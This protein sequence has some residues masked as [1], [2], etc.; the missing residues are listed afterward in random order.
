MNTYDP[1]GSLHQYR[2][3]LARRELAATITWAVITVVASMLILAAIDITLS[4]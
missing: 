4:L 1:D 2:L 3:E